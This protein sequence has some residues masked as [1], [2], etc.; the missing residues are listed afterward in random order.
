MA[1]DGA[2]A[3]TS[4]LKSPLRGFGSPHPPASGSQGLSGCGEYSRSLK[5]RPRS[6]RFPVRNLIHFPLSGR[7]A[8]E[9]LY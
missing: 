5:A 9:R 6:A 1:A 3:R 8:G 7:L 4:A 2:D